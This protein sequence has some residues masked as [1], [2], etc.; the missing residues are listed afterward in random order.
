MIYYHNM[1]PSGME[2]GLNYMF[3]NWTSVSIHVGPTNAPEFLV[4][5]NGES[6]MYSLSNFTE[7]I[8]YNLSYNLNQL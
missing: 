2:Q 5:F 4:D 7:T 8:F 1:N 6:S 3:F